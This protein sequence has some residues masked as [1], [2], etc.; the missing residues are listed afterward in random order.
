MKNNKAVGINGIPSEF[1]QNL[2]VKSMKELVKLCQDMYDHGK[3]PSDFTKL[4]LIPIEKNTN[5]VSV[6]T[7][8]QS[9]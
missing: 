5:A 1:L 8:G 2:G 4:V 7:T 6:K 3:W 9:V